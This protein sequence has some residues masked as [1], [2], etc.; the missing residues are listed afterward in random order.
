MKYFLSISVCVLLLSC[1][2]SSQINV[3]GL[4]NNLGN[5]NNNSSTGLT[6]SQMIDGLKQALQIG[7]NNA[8]STLNKTDGYFKNVAIKILMPPE[9]KAVEDKLRELGFGSKVDEAIL[10]M[11]RAAETAAKDA[12]PIFLDAIKNMTISDAASIV[13]GTDHAATDYLKSHTS[14]ALTQKFTPVISK[15]LST[16]NATKYW[17]D[18]FTTYNKIPFVTKV[19]PDL[20]S[21]VTQKALEGLF[22]QIGLEEKKIRTD[23]AAQVTTLLQQLFGKH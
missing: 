7:T 12:A 6:N 9:A 21:Y 17:S 5:S 23:P 11:N 15:A 8:T 4:L 10:S 3:G 1:S 16:V 14:T 20:T 2:A 18:V 22:Y 13:T 19:N